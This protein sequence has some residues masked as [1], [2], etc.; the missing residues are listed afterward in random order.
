MSFSSSS[1]AHADDVLMSAHNCKRIITLN[2]PKTLNALNMPM[3]QEM[4]PKLK[5]SL[6]FESIFI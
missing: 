5:L 2:R 3:I 4:F 6:F 1:T